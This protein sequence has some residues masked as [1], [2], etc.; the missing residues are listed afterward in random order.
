[1]FYGSL[2]LR[3]GFYPEDSLSGMDGWLNVTRTIFV[4]TVRRADDQPAQ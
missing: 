4:F 3:G 2:T 1:L